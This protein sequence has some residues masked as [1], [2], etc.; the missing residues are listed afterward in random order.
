MED[1]ILNISAHGSN[2]SN[3]TG[4]EQEVLR[5]LS[6]DDNI[7]IK[8][9]D[10]GSAVVVWDR[11]DYLKEAENHLGDNTTY[12]A[13][14]GDP[15]PNLIQLVSTTLDIMARKGEIDKKMQEYLLA[16][17]PRLGRFYLL[18]KVHKR[19]FNVRS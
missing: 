10:K 5:N 6:R 8:G 14:D 17:K 18:S 19:S 12:E 2:Y 1:E 13:V 16:T 15:M 9:A 7:I 11:E 3:L 4:E